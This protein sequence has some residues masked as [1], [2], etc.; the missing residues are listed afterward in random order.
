MSI[1]LSCTGTFQDLLKRIWNSHPLSSLFFQT[2]REWQVD[3]GQSSTNSLS[4]S[5]SIDLS[6]YHRVLSLLLP[7]PLLFS[8]HIRCLSYSEFINNW[9]L[10]PWPLQKYDR[11]VLIFIHLD[12]SAALLHYRS[13]QSSL[14]FMNFYSSKYILKWV[15]SLTCRSWME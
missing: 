13:E 1:Q 10:K 12:Y 14:A 15:L 11:S 4:L 6:T 5:P 2:R 7:F 8:P 3:D 9:P